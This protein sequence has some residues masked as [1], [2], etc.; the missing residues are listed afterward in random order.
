MR[1]NINYEHIVTILNQN[2]KDWEKLKVLSEYLED[3]D[4]S[5]ILFSKWKLLGKELF[6]ENDTSLTLA[7]FY[8]ANRILRYTPAARKDSVLS[9]DNLIWALTTLNSDYKSYGDDANKLKVDL[10]RRALLIDTKH[11]LDLINEHGPISDSMRK[12]ANDIAEIA[13]DDSLDYSSKLMGLTSIGC[14]TE[15]SKYLINENTV[16]AILDQ[17]IS[18]LDSQ[19]DK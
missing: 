16:N 5:S 13:E 9:A 6:S 4:V 17:I 12:K 2:Q 1:K 14:S 18:T 19:P 8:W 10:L 15:L 7:D 3:D 11:A